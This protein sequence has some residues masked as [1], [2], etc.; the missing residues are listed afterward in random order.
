MKK[1]KMKGGAEVENEISHFK[2]SAYKQM[3]N[4]LFL[5]FIFSIAL[6]GFIWFFIS[7]FLVKHMYSE[8]LCYSLMLISIVFSLFLM[9]SIAVIRMQGS[10]FMKQFLNITMFV[11]TKCL[12]GFIVAIQL[13]IMIKLMKDNA[14]Y[15]YSTPT[16]DRPEL[17]DVFNGASAFG[18]ITQM[19]MYRN[20]LY[21]VIFPQGESQ[22]Y[23][24]VLGFI[25]V[26]ILTSWCI[27]QMYVILNYL[28]VDG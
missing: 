6:M 9:T 11:L 2:K 22:S 25:L 4:K 10:N 18:L 1:R 21:R 15:L 27:G 7:T 16:E 26:G 24:T 3:D 23:T 17:F 20:H 19:F 28:K 8:V 12:P 13:V 5:N 14:L